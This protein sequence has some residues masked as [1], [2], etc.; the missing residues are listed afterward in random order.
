MFVIFDADG[1]NARASLAKS[2]LPGENSFSIPKELYTEIMQ[3][4]F[5]LRELTMSRRD[6]LLVVERL[7]N[8]PRSNQT[9]EPVAFGKDGDIVLAIRWGGMTMEYAPHIRKASTHEFNFCVGSVLNPLCQPVRLSHGT[10]WQMEYILA[11]E[12]MPF[13][14]E[15][16]SKANVFVSRPYINFRY[17][18]YLDF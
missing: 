2:D 5:V 16:F 10:L 1:Q 7:T 12:Q 4:P 13:R 17:T 6:G 18:Y 15:L 8:I 3:N 14:A 9:M 11:P